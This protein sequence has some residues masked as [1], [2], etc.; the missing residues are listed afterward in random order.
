MGV[1]PWKMPR[2][3][4]TSFSKRRRSRKNINTLKWGLIT[5]GLVVLVTICVWRVQNIFGN[6]GSSH[7]LAVLHRA[8]V[9]FPRTNNILKYW[10][11]GEESQCQDLRDWRNFWEIL[12]VQL[13]NWFL[14]SSQLLG[15]QFEWKE[16]S[17]ACGNCSV[18]V[19][20]FVHFK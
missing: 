17:I 19:V 10:Y 5:T 13:L 12:D 6:G 1:G 7:L 3:V 15:C 14:S 16:S 11:G 9:F 4:W 20:A 8:I 18:T 2:H